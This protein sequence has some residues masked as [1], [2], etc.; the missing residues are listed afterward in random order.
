MADELI[1]YTN[2]MSRRRI[3]RWMETGAPYTTEILGFESS[4]KAP[5]Y[6]A[7]NP[8][9]KVPAIRHGKTVVTEC[10]AICAYLAEAFP[11]A[12][13][14]PTARKNAAATI[15][16]DVL[17]RRPSGS[18]NHQP[19]ARLSHARRQNRM[20]GYG[21]YADVM[22]T[23]RKGRQRL[24]LYRRQPLHGGRCLC[25]V[26]CGLG[27][28]PSAPSRSA[29]HLPITSVASPTAPP[30]SGRAR[31]DDEATESAA[32]ERL[33]GRLRVQIRGM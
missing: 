10:A 13:L 17:R 32:E 24:A 33:T 3:A 22:D 9:G 16:L 2:P 12:G 21:S 28:S 14:A 19:R 20:A 18:R 6:L 25:R 8:M 27:S 5:D 7:I 15:A 29:R 11:E 1:F 26:A 31:S 23:L 30:P 4:M